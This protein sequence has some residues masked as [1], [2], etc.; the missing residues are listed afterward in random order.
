MLHPI[1]ESVILHYVHITTGY[2]DGATMRFPLD[3]L[4]TH[5]SPLLHAPHRS[6]YEAMTDMST[7]GDETRNNESDRPHES[8][9]RSQGRSAAEPTT[10]DGAMIGDDGVGLS[11]AN[12]PDDDLPRAIDDAIAELR[13]VLSRLQMAHADARGAEPL[14]DAMDRVDPDRTLDTNAS[15]TGSGRA[16][17]ILR[18]ISRTLKITAER[19]ERVSSNS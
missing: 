12:P 19:I 3:T 2:I 13:D 10:G 6:T 15:S 9:H 16:R 14:L 7:D 8:N 1:P 4:R 11:V 5:R 17:S 18:G